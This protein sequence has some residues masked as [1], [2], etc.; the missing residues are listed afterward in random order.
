[1][2]FFSFLFDETTGDL[3]NEGDFLRRP[4]YAQTLKDLANADNP[5]E[6]FYRGNM[7]KIAVSEIQ[8]DGKRVVLVYSKF[9]ATILC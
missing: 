4:V 9:C 3:H 7:A 1:M 5:V 8:N 2:E 6:L